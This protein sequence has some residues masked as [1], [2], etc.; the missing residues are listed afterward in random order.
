MYFKQKT[1]VYEGGNVN[2]RIQMELWSEEDLKNKL[3]V[4]FF[5]N[6]DFD[7]FDMEFE[8][9]FEVT[10]GTKKIIVHSDILVRIRGHPVIIIE[11]KRPSHKISSVDVNQAISYAR[12]CKSRIVE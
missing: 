3:V 2:A 6:R 5:E 9:P 11:T 1:L 8:R 7:L 12:L 10:V 4:P